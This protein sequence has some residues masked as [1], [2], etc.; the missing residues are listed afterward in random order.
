MSIET[1]PVRI[2]APASKSLSHRAFTGA[3]LAKGT[4]RVTLALDSVDLD[5]TRGILAACGAEIVKN[6]PG[7][8]TVTGV[9]GVPR[10]GTT[11]PV[12]LDVHESGTTCRLL[13]G[14]V[15]AGKGSFHIHGAERMHERPMGNLTDALKTQG[16]TFEWKGKP[17]Y[18]PF[19]LFTDGL[20]GGTV[21]IGLDESS[22]YLS[23][24]LLAAPMAKK[25][26]TIEITG[27]KAVSWPYAALTLMTLED[28]GLSFSV[29]QKIKGAWKEVDWRAVKEV[30]PGELRFHMAPGEYKARDLRVEGDWSNASYFLAAGALG[31]RPVTVRGLRS[32]S[33]QGDKAI[34]DIL[35]AM[36]ADIS[37]D[38]DEVTV[39]PADLK[40]VDVDMGACP[41]LVPTVAV[42]AAL[43]TGR[44]IIR[45]VAHLRIKE[46]DRLAAMADELS[47]VGCRTEVL[48]DGLVLDPE[49]M[50]EE[51]AFDQVKFKTYGDHRVAMSLSLLSLGGEGVHLDNPGC[52]SKSFPGFFDAFKEVLANGGE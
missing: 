16:V 11:E 31:P 15:A 2:T 47:R 22:Q 23:G 10:G 51:P 52:V 19:V 37:W 48:P 21:E 24:L 6:G 18:P 25:P 30:K 45:N 39:S 1:E 35:G 20:P 46:C 12:S 50:P 5:K 42:T 27:K 43:A 49:T 28:F 3:A 33:L 26:M 17:D 40:G 34:L 13:T 44:T 9:A 29:E 38:G 32:D 8:Y 14:V 41:D 4:S 7:D 36:G